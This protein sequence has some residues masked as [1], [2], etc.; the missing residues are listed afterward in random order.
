M[1]R[2]PPVI[3]FVSPHLFSLSNTGLSCFSRSTCTLDGAFKWADRSKTNR[4]RSGVDVGL[5]AGRTDSVANYFFPPLRSASSPFSSCT[6]SLMSPK[7]KGFAKRKRV[8]GSRER[9]GWTAFC[10]FLSVSSLLTCF[11]AIL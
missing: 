7:L 9:C 5:K 1:S 3:L 8:E 10:A 2:S 11:S 6:N 4:S